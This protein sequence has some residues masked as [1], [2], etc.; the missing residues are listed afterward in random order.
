MRTLAS[1]LQLI[2]AGSLLVAA[3]YLAR[4]VDPDIAER[5]KKEDLRLRDYVI[6]HDLE[7][8]KSELITLQKERWATYVAHNRKSWLLLTMVTAGL[9]VLL[10]ARLITWR[11]GR[12][13]KK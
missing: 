10:V 5:E 11:S 1:I 3:I 4:E 12:Q 9:V 13:Q 8:V 2:A 7:Y 6:S